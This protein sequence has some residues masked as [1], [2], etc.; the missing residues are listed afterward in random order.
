MGASK[1]ML[2]GCEQEYAVWWCAVGTFAIICSVVTILARP[3]R[4]ALAA[5]AVARVCADTGQAALRVPAVA[6]TAQVA[7]AIALFLS[8]GGRNVD[9]KNAIIAQLCHVPTDAALCPVLQLG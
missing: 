2:Y 3:P 8:R 7:A 5:K 1:N 9:F 4:F 6:I